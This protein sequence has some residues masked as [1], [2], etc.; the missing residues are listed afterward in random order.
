M[1]SFAGSPKPCV[2]PAKYGLRNAYVQ[3]LRQILV[4]QKD[5]IAHFIK[6]GDGLDSYDSAIK[7]ARRKLDRA[8]KLYLQHIHTHQC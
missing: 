3:A 6:G 7:Q 5:E 4:L 2:C 1:A 8:K